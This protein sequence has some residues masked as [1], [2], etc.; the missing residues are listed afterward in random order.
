MGKIDKRSKEY[1]DAHKPSEG[2][3]DTIEK[4]TEATGIKKL[5]NIIFGDDCGCEERKKKLNKLFKYKRVECLELE[6]YNYLGTVLPYLKDKIEPEEQ[7]KVL[8]IYNR[9]FN[10]KQKNTSCATCWR[11]I[12]KE[13]NKLYKEYED[14]INNE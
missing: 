1:R 14:E 12:I 2:L 13:M 7:V 4:I 9:V 11:K 6:E 5:V 3:G 10:D 8:A